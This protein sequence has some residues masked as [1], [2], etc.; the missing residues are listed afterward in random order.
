MKG[1]VR[2]IEQNHISN[3]FNESSFGF[4]GFQDDV[5]V[6]TAAYMAGT[7]ARCYDE[8][9]ITDHRN[10][11]IEILRRKP[12]SIQFFPDTFGNSIALPSASSPDY[13]QAL[14]TLSTN[15]AN[16]FLHQKSLSPVP[17]VKNQVSC[18]GCKGHNG[19]IKH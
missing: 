2:Y 15:F 11:F 19:R 7:L 1:F 10:D 3:L 4:V 18:L 14:A 13:D 17:Q 12:L 8:T 6:Q 16:D 9:V 5:L